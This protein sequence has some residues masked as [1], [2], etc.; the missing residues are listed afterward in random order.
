VDIRPGFGAA[1]YLSRYVA[2]QV[3]RFNNRAAKDNPLN[4]SD[5][6]ALAMS[7]ASGKRLTYAQL[8]DKGASSFHR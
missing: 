6:F 3:F 4:D 2:E 1:I 8:I 7:Q 5:R